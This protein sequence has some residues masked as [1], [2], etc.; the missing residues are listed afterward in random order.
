MLAEKEV[1]VPVS[2]VATD[3][4][5]VAIE[6]SRS[7]WVVGTHIPDFEQGWHSYRRMGR[8]GRVADARR[9]ASPSRRRRDRGDRRA[10]HVLLRGRVRGLLALPPTHGRGASS[11]RDRPIEPSG[12]PPRQARQDG[13]YRRQGDD[14]CAD[15]LQPR[16]RPGALRGQRPRR[17]AGGPSSARPGTPKL[18]LRMH[19]AYEPHQ[20]LANDAGDRWLR[21]SRRRRRPAT[22]RARHR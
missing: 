5:F 19:G 12:Q 4:I 16:R 3:P 14:P 10:D 2:S 22:R 15:G 6:M 13:P 18:G 20:G 1:T 8:R 9:T 11:A 21:F 17:R 7:K